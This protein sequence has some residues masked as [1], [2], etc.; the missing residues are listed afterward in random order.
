MGKKGRSKT[1]RIPYAQLI[2]FLKS[3]G[4][5]Y[6]VPVVEV[7]TYHTSKWCPH[8]GAINRG[9]CSKNY[10]LYKCKTCGLIVNSDRKASLCVGVKSVVERNKSHKLTSFDSIQISMTRVRVNGLLRPQDA[11]LSKATV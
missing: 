10:A 5:I 1:N 9:H 6:H 2:E 8:C 7:D 3:N 11:N 4:K